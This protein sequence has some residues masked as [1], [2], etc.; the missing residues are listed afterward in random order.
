MC[1]GGCPAENLEDTG[2][3]YRRHSN[4]CELTRVWTR[5]GRHVYETMMAEQ[6]QT[7]LDNYCDNPEAPPE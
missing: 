5:V 3:I 7:F 6:N 4:A 1:S 2:S